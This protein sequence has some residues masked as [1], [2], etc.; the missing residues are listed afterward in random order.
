M[1]KQVAM[2]GWA[3]EGRAVDVVYV[4]FRKA[5]VTLSILVMKLKKRGQ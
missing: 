1:I 5:F 2:S 3:D 4:D